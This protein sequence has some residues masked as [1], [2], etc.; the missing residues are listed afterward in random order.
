[1]AERSEY[2]IRPGQTSF[3]VPVIELDSHGQLQAML[4]N[5]HFG[6]APERSVIAPI[7]VRFEYDGNKIPRV[8]AWDLLSGSQ[9]EGVVA[10]YREPDLRPQEIP[11]PT[12]VVLA[13]DCSSSMAGEKIE[14]ARSALEEIA[15]TYLR[16]A[17]QRSVAVVNFGGAHSIYPSR[18]LLMPTQSLEAVRATTRQLVAEGDTPMDAGLQSVRQVLD[19]APG[20]RLAIVLTDGQPNNVETSRQTAQTLRALQIQIGV[21][22]IGSDANRDFLNS[23]K[24]FDSSIVVDDSGKGMAA[25]VLDI[26]TKA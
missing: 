3:Q 4:G 21:V 8:S 26:L 1:M 18:I 12:T 13:I 11:T 17:S 20:R 9:L 15:Q 5:Y 24:D 7:R 25:A 10:D 2:Y 22:P 16:G 19:S 6:G 23:I 14:Q